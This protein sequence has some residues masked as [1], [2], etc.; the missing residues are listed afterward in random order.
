MYVNDMDR[1]ELLM[2]L[3]NYR[4]APG[5]DPNYEKMSDDELRTL[6]ERFR[7]LFEEE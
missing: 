6:L 4:F 5:H 3:G 1:E 2:E 7:K